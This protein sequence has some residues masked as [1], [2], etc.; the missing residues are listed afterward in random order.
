MPIRA[1]WTLPSL[2][3]LSATFAGHVDRDGEA[4]AVVAARAHAAAAGHDR[5]VDADHLAVSC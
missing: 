4:D 5:R 3:S 1:R 2:I